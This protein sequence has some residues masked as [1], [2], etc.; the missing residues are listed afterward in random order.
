MDLYQIHNLV[1]WQDHLPVLEGLKEAG[2][3]A[4]IGATHYRAGAFSDL[5]RVMK[6]GRITVIQIPYN[7]VHREVE[8]L[9]LP[10][11]ADL[12]LGVV[13]MR[14]FGEGSLM[15][16]VPPPI[17]SYAFS[18]LWHK[19]LGSGVAE[20]D[21]ERCQVPRGDPRNFNTRAH[22]RKC[23]RREPAVV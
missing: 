1:S 5:A 22:G 18:G 23:E 11:A 16:R 20:M 9:I 15:R 3:I 13:V 14:P 2:Q 21:S 19:V 6:T 17:Q 8:S 12:D 7:P 4:A 10:L